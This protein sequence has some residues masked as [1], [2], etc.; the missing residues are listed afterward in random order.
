MATSPA[1]NMAADGRSFR[2]AGERPE[3]YERSSIS[4]GILEPPGKD[5]NA[6][7]SGGGLITPLLCLGPSGIIADRR[8]ALADWPQGAE[9]SHR[10]GVWG[11]SL[12]PGARREVATPVV[13]HRLHR[14]G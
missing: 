14:I 7:S 2:V 8:R 3:A 11:Q 13:D 12:C 10:P 5:G 9:A 6:A 1:E 4:E